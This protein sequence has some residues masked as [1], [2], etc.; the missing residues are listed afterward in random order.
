[1][2]LSRWDS[3]LLSSCRSFLSSSLSF[4]SSLYCS[5]SDRPPF[6]CSW[7]WVTVGASP[8]QSTHSRR[9]GNLTLIAASSE[10]P[11]SLAAERF[12]ER[13]LLSELGH[14]SALERRCA[15][16]LRKAH[17]LS[18]PSHPSLASRKS[19]RSSAR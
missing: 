14:A 17:G 6:P 3:F 7:P 4:L 15:G 5:S 12:F 19:P 1:M 10:G 18:L 13:A 2:S 11:V 8:V 9:E 16:L